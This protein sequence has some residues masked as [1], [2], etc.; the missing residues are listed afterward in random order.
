M[1][2]VH[3]PHSGRSQSGKFCGAVLSLETMTE[4]AEQS[5][6]RLMELRQQL[7]AKGLTEANA[8]LY[9]QE[10]AD[11]FLTCHHESGTCLSEAITLLCEM[12]SQTD[13]ALA[14][15]GSSGL[16]SRLIER[17]N[18]AF[19][20]EYCALY[21][22]VFAQVIE[23]CRKRNPE[24]DECLRRFDLRDEADLLARKTRLTSGQPATTDW[25][26]VRKMIL[27][28]RV[29][30]GA[31]VAVTS[32]MMAAVR[33][34]LPQA[35]LVLLGSG[36]LQ[37]L[38]GGDPRVR[39][40][41]VAYERGGSLISRLSAWPAVVSAIEQEREGYDGAEVCIIDPDSRLTQLGMLPVV[42]SD[43]GY[44]FF[45][46]RS[47]RQPGLNRLSVLTEHWINR[48]FGTEKRAFPY[49]AVPQKEQLAGQE[50]A[51]RLRRGGAGHLVCVSFGVGG[52]ARKRL[53]D[54]FEEEL[55]NG[56]LTDSTLILDKGGSEEE[57]I[58]INRL[59]EGLRSRGRTVVEV[60]ADNLSE[61]LA[62]EAIHTD[63]LTWQ[64]GI[65]GLAG[66]TGASDEYVGYD[67]AGQHIAA[68]LGV[69]TLT[70]FVNSGS[71]LFAE[72]WHP[73]GPGQVRVLRVEP[74]EEELTE[75]RVQKV[76]AEALTIHWKLSRRTQ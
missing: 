65:G 6:R 10:A 16:F 42:D 66:L 44:F 20:P 56:L 21:D 61:R 27:L 2:R 35:E 34:F 30:L 13:E 76:L 17:L 60:N 62:N 67:S 26:R 25:Q 23:F 11:T 1:R 69:P 9:A 5:A 3:L 32:V 72:R 47:Y 33:E 53:P 38:F 54:S 50:I 14:R 46:S 29:T 22:R 36:K 31:D 63:V 58:Q 7:S 57:R 40:H 4:R 49:V 68:A 24:F 37:Q 55:L 70:V 12:A 28:S 45:E 39:I 15:A 74:D 75:S 43:A 18:D 48:L 19:E 52:N 41:E 64:G 8:T 73:H 51:L 71:G 59:I